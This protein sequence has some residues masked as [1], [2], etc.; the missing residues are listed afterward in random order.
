MAA[1]HQIK[2]KDRLPEMGDAEAE[3]MGANLTEEWMSPGGSCG[4]GDSPS[5][6]CYRVIPLE[7]DHLE[8]EARSALGKKMVAK[9]RSL[10]GPE[11]CWVDLVV[12]W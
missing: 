6:V 5:V 10:F 1:I 8:R 4:D 12:F 7:L 2:S 9:I 3:W 11:D